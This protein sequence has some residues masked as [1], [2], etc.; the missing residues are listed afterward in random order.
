MKYETI[1]FIYHKIREKSQIN[2]YMKKV[3]G[4]CMM[5]GGSTNY[6]E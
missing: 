5:E 2:M 4:I 6:P 3:R 1:Y